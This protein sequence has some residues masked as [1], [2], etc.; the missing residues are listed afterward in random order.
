[1]KVIKT[2]LFFLFCLSIFAEARAETPILDGKYYDWNVY[3]LVKDN[4]EKFCYIASYAKESIGNFKGSRKPYIM[5]TY[6]KHKEK[7]E[8]S[9]YGDFVYKMNSMIY[10]SVDS[11]QYKLL[12]KDKMAWV[13]TETEDKQLISSLLNGKIVKIRSETAKGEYSV[14][15]YS[16]NGLPVAYN[17]MKIL[18]EN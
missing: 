14:D 16:T 7:E 2:F 11:I 1:M 13:K 3:K 18:C 9:V 5:I 12:T 10:L 15:T 6:F 17:R 4:G 8:V